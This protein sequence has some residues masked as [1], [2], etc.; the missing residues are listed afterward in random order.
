VRDV[1]PALSRAGCNAGSC[2]AKPEG[3]NGFKLS[4]FCYDPRS[5][6]AEIVRKARGRRVFP[7]APDESLL[8]QKPLTAVPHEAA[9]GSSAGLKPIGC[10][11]AGCARGWPTP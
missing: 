4:V 7:A 3:Q 10:S 1:L 6:Y 2:H 8:L 9:S 5:D 11:P